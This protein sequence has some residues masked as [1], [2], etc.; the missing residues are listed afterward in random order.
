MIGREIR[1]NQLSLESL[2][3]KLVNNNFKYCFVPNTKLSYNIRRFGIWCF[4]CLFFWSQQH[5]SSLTWENDDRIFFFGLTNQF[6]RLKR[7]CI[8][9]R[10]QVSVRWA[11][12]SDAFVPVKRW[13]PVLPSL[14]LI[15]FTAELKG[16]LRRSPPSSCSSF[17]RRCPSG[18]QVYDPRV[19]PR[20]LER[21]V[22][23]KNSPSCALTRKQLAE[24]KSAR[25][26]GV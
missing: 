10:E 11:P 26:V 3:S 16:V 20:S 6:K 12:E 23:I 9:E 14:T 4:I 1:H 19:P 2:T 5:P 18:R 22:F 15:S 25:K 7:V 17:W 24:R 13:N 8:C 21:R